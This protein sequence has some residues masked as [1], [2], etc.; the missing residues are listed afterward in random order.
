[1]I[2]R[3]DTIR[4]DPSMLL[5]ESR[6]DLIESSELLRVVARLEMQR[7]RQ[8]GQHGHD[9]LSASATRTCSVLDMAAPL[10]VDRV[11]D[12]SGGHAFAERVFDAC[13]EALRAV[14]AGFMIVID[15]SSDRLAP[16]EE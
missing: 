5:D 4:C 13:T 3:E 15:E 2:A 10:E 7:H 8:V 14:V 16:V 11:H 9:R 1:V 12:L 6:D